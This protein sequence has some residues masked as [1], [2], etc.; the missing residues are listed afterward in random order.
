MPKKELDQSESEEITEVFR[1]IQDVSIPV[2][3]DFVRSDMTVEGCQLELDAQEGVVVVKND[4]GSSVVSFPTE[5]E[6]VNLSA[7]VDGV[8][9]TARHMKS[10]N[11]HLVNGAEALVFDLP[12]ML[13]YSQRREVFR[14]QVEEYLE[15]PVGI[16]AANTYA[17]DQS[18][19]MVHGRLTTISVQGCSIV[20]A[21]ELCNEIVD[22]KLP[23]ILQLNLA[24]QPDFPILYA[25]LRN[26]RLDSSSQL[27]TLGFQFTEN[28]R[29]ARKMLGQFSTHVQLLARGRKVLSA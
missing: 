25:L 21:T 12:S 8:K 22:Y 24:D 19:A 2:T 14:A 4:E 18:T 6:G 15:V 28:D 9:V 23:I 17:D 3:L 20:L 10:R 27:T 1:T 11:T 13:M 26:H 16:F 29:R 5:E 7:I